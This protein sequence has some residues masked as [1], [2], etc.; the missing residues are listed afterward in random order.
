MKNL[1]KI[2][3][4]LLLFI[5]FAQCSSDS[6]SDTEGAVEPFRVGDTFGG[7]LTVDEDG[8]LEGTVALTENNTIF[9][10]SRDVERGAI[11]N[12]INYITRILRVTRTYL[13]IRVE[14]SPSNGV[15]PNPTVF[16]ATSV[17][18][19]R[20]AYYNYFSG[21][22]RRSRSFRRGPIEHTSNGR[23]RAVYRVPVAS[24]Q[25][26]IG[27][28][29]LEFRMFIRGELVHS[30]EDGLICRTCCPLQ[31]RDRPNCLRALGCGSI[32]CSSA[33]SANNTSSLTTVANL[34]FTSRVI[35]TGGQGR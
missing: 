5:Q 30:R 4:L 21:L 28:R 32:D 10:E 3:Y 35:A 15:N 8:N 23:L 29:N 2:L 16:S 17:M 19:M 31:S 27:A 6:E 1:I 22:R 7:D 12:R 9:R 18:D 25:N 33:N 26:I 14:L 34:N 13:D 24:N 20:A 11:N